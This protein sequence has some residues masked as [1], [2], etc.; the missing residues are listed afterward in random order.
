MVIKKQTLRA[1]SA[2]RIASW[3]NNWL[4]RM[5]LRTSTRQ[6]LRNSQAVSLICQKMMEKTT[7]SQRHLK[8][9]TLS[10]KTITEKSVLTLM[11]STTS[12]N[13]SKKPSIPRK[14]RRPRRKTPQGETATRS[15]KL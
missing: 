2:A 15:L 10:L 11:K 5:K 13:L 8:L 3:R 4:K 14:P 1:S 9:T 7:L 12:R 6:S